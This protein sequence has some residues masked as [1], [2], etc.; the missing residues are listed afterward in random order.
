VFID[1]RALS[2]QVFQDYRVILGSP[3]GDPARARTLERYGV[4]AIVVPTA[5][6]YNSG[7]LYPLVPA[8]D[9]VAFRCRAG[10]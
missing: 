10:T 1:G 2:E 4:T 5:F 7:T 6:E 9:I 3:P 8:A